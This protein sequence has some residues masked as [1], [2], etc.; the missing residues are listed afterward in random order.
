MKKVLPLLLLVFVLCQCSPVK[1]EK[2]PPTPREQYPE[3]FTT[4]YVNQSAKKLIDY[5]PDHEFN[6]SIKR[7]FNEEYYSLL[8]ESWAVPVDDIMGIGENEWLYYFMTGNGG[9]EEFMDHSKNIL[10]TVVMDDY[11]AWVQMEYLGRIHDIV[12]HFENEDWVI[13]NFDGTK[14]QMLR[15][16]RDQRTHLRNINWQQ[17]YDV[18]I[19][20]NK[21]YIPEEEI[22]A[23]LDEFKAEVNAYLAKYPDR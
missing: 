23:M 19:E 10:E 2:R 16:I 21:A 22:V 17:Y 18:T 15:Y 20:D 9:D 1:R 8:E 13:S 12:M 5:V 6:P 14:D 3:K 7:Y 11:N 4:D